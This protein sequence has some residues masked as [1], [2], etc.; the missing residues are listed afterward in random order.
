ML[1]KFLHKLASHPWV[2][3]RIQELAGAG[4]VY[5]KLEAHLPRSHEKLCVLDVGGGTGTLKKLWPKDSTYICLDIDPT[6]LKG[7]REKEPQGLA[8]LG[9]ALKMPF[10]DRSVDVLVCMFVA[11]HLDDKMFAAGIREFWRIIKPS[12]RLLFLDPLRVPDRLLSRVLWA[13]DRGECPRTAESL[14]AHLETNFRLTHWETFSIYHCYILGVGEVQA[15]RK[16]VHGAPM[17]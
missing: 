7:F 3:D 1:L 16:T 17:L 13:L 14:R 10:A 8:V 5:H 9:D 2:Y 6:K 11:H 4:Q 12:G 15:A